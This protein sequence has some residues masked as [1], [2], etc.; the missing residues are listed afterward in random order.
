MADDVGECVAVDVGLELPAC[1]VRVPGAD[2]FGLEALELL[3]RAEFVG[4]YGQSVDAP[5]PDDG[6][7]IPYWS[8]SN[9]GRCC[10][11]LVRWR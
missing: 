1:R 8:L 6:G 9:S 11:L 10:F 7:H 4:L 2:V 5:G 3:L